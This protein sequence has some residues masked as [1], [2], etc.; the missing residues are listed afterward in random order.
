VDHHGVVE[1]LAGQLAGIDRVAVD[2][3][4]DA[5][6][7]FRILFLRRQFGLGPQ[8]GEWGADLVR[9][10]GQKGLHGLQIGFQ[11]RHQLVDR[12]DKL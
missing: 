9:R 8:A 1:Q 11:A 4:D 7:F 5:A 3:M 10:V 12:A 2:A 6:Q